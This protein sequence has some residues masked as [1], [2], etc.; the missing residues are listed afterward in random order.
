MALFAANGTELQHG[1]DV[2]FGGSPP[3]TFHGLEYSVAKGTILEAKLVV[4]M[5][6]GQGSTKVGLAL[7][8][9]YE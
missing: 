2:T 6:T 7:F 3:T 5:R 9:P 8:E 4:R 1:W